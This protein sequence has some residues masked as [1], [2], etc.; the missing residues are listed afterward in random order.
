MKVILLK[1]VPKIGKKYDIKDVSDGYALNMLIPQKKAE[2]ATDAHIKKVKE[3]KNR[4]EDE[5]KIQESLLL[6]NFNT[7][8]QKQ[9]IIKEKANEKG[10]LFAQVH[11]PEIIKA[12]K[13]SLGADIDSAHIDLSKPIKETGEHKVGI[14]I[15]DKKGFVVITIEAL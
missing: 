11:I 1:D 12:I 8:D 10:H 4:L 3:L 6:A 14:R 9:I 7:I 5:R 13:N 15:G 2:V